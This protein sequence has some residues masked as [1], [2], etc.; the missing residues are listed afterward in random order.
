[1]KSKKELI[2]ILENEKAIYEKIAEEIQAKESEI[3][4][5]KQTIN[6]LEK[7]RG[8][9]GD[10]LTTFSYAKAEITPEEYFREY[11]YERSRFHEGK[12]TREQLH[13]LI[14]KLKEKKETTNIMPVIRTWEL[15]SRHDYKINGTVYSLHI[16]DNPANYIYKTWNKNENKYYFVS[17]YERPENKKYKYTLEMAYKT[18]YDHEKE[19]FNYKTLADLVQDLPGKMEKLEAIYK[20]DNKDIFETITDFLDFG[21]I[22]TTIDEYPNELN[23]IAGKRIEKKKE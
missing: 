16:S 23:N 9:H 11:D 10:I 22:E 1:M 6:E 19:K 21:K 7:S 4:K 3:W 18:G 12:I 17:F 2:E 5:I 8:L 20:E 13:E 14:K 15:Y